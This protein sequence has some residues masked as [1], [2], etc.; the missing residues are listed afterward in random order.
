MA[1]TTKD[2]VTPEPAASEE[3]AA[4]LTNKPAPIIAPIPKAN[5]DQAPNVVLR[6]FSLEAASANKRDNDFFLKIVNFSF[7][8]LKLYYPLDYH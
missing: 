3:A 5:K 6:P 2:N 1:A 4:V 8:N 7:K